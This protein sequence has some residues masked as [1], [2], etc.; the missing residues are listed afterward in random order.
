MGLTRE[1]ILACC[2]L[3]LCG[4]A[5][6]APVGF[7][8]DGA[9]GVALVLAGTVIVVTIVRS[10]DRVARQRA[11]DALRQMRA[12]TE[13]ADRAR[14]EFLANL[15]HE[16]HAPL[17]HTIGMIERALETPLTAEQRTH[18]GA[19]WAS[20]DSMLSVATSVLNYSAAEAGHV[21]PDAVPFDLG[22]VLDETMSPLALRAQAKGLEFVL[23]VD[24]AA[25]ET[26]V[27]DPARLTQALV[28]MVENAIT[29]T[30]TGEV[31]VRADMESREDDSVVLHATVSDTG[32]GIAP[33]RLDTLFDIFAQ[34][35][36]AAARLT[37]RPG[38]G[39][40]I[41]SR[42]ARLM[43]GRAWAES[44][45]G[46]GSA[47]HLTA[48][49]GV[50]EDEQRDLSAVAMLLRGNSVAVV[51]DNIANLR[52]VER[53]LSHWGMSV[54]VSADAVTAYTQLLRAQ[55][56]GTPIQLLIADSR[57]PGIDAFALTERIRRTSE[58]DTTPVIVMQPSHEHW[59]VERARALDIRA[60]VVKPLRARALRDAIAAELL[61]AL[62]TPDN[63]EPV[64]PLTGRRSV[65]PLRILLAD[66]IAIDRLTTA[67]LLT[68]R[69]HHVEVASNGRLALDALERERFDIVLMD[70]QMPEMNGVE[71]TRRLRQREQAS[72]ARRTPVVLFASRD[73]VDDETHLLEAGMDAYLPKPFRRDELYEMVEGTHAQVAA[74]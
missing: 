30:E 6:C 7:L 46:S 32:I 36:T 37:E 31:V 47:F 13:A 19:A 72:G 61:G 35:G 56:D 9:P 59:D 57:M 10:K 69:G 64:A 58:I 52:G 14:T 66:A 42:C 39:L 48:R 3:L 11:E 2:S 70:V 60:M 5:S 28:K 44:T 1:H 62:H 4:L 50:E 51:D 49:V 45:P 63:A 71:A 33:E 74:A 16:L 54:A 18:L 21:Q 67:N 20:A 34:P 24:P 38:L 40:A 41:V 26:L 65:R 43:G 23:D 25:P 73:M 17:A 15:S 22:A 53:T 29:C 27:G 68:K 8:A 55:L 12:N